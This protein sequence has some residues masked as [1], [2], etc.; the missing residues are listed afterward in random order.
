MSLGL[1]TELCQLLEDPGDLFFGLDSLPVMLL[2]PE[3]DLT[4]LL[5][6]GCVCLLNLIHGLDTLGRL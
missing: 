1:D 2:K 6:K 5:L 3:I 4:E